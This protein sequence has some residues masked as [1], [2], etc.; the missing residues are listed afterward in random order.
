M[1]LITCTCV[2]LIGYFNM[3]FCKNF[4][5]NIPKSGIFLNPFDPNNFPS[6]IQ[7]LYLCLFMMEHLPHFYL[8]FIFHFQFLTFFQK[9]SSL[10]TLHFCSKRAFVNYYIYQMLKEYKRVGRSNRNNSTYSQL[11]WCFNLKLVF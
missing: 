11:F 4:E 9:I 7:M 1:S 8:T 10:G 3:Y 2:F 5:S 6:E